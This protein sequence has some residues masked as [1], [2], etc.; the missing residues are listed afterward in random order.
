MFHAILSPHFDD[1]VLSRWQLLDRSSRRDGRER[2]HGRTPGRD[3]AAV[4]GPCDRSNRS[5]RAYARTAPGGC[6]GAGSRG[7]V[8]GA[9]WPAGS[10]STAAP[11]CRCAR[12]SSGSPRSLRPQAIIHAPGA[13]DGHPDHV[14]VRDAALELARAGR[15]VVL[16]ADLPHASARGWPAWL[17]GE[18]S[19]AGERNRGRLGPCAPRSRARRARASSVAFIAL[20][21]PN[22]CA[23]APG[24][25]RGTSPSAPHWTDTR[26]PLSMTRARSRGRSAGRC[27]PQ[28]CAAWRS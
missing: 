10:I 17:S 8:V 20:D 13:F 21:A 23:K 28:R 18:P 2:L 11:N 27:R 15:P 9:A 6:G 12:S 22:T 25:G 16:Y 19:A 26:S 4:V 1:A 24:A 3:S 7:E 5:C 14:L